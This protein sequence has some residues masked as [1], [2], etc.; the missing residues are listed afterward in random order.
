MSDA[1]SLGAGL[2]LTN[3]SAKCGGVTSATMATGATINCT[4]G[5]G[6]LLLGGTVTVVAA[7][8]TVGTFNSVGHISV[9]VDYN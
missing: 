2:S 7:S 9:S 6:S 5:P 8:A 4:A 1:T 3:V